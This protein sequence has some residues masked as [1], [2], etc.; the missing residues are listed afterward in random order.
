MPYIVALEHGVWLTKGVGD[1][2]RTTDREKAGVWLTRNSANR[3]LRKA[4]EYRPF[5]TAS[6][7]YIPVDDLSMID[8]NLTVADCRPR[9]SLTPFERF[10]ERRGFHADTCQSTVDRDFFALAETLYKALARIGDQGNRA[11][12]TADLKGRHARMAIS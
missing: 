6:V 3:Y 10:L 7:N 2:P 4:R 12:P 11:L 5:C 9:K 8:S 1:P